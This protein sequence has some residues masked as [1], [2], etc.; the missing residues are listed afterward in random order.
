MT[1][2]KEGVWGGVCTSVSVRWITI[3]LSFEVKSYTDLK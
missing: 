1:W 2:A 3:C